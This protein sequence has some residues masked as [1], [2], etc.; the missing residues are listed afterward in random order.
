MLKKIGLTAGTLAIVLLGGFF[1]STPMALAQTANFWTQNALNSLATNTSGGLAT[2]DIHVAHCYIGLGTGTSCGSGGSMTSISNSDGTL[3]LSPDP[4]TTTGTVSINLLN[5]NVWT[6]TAGTFFNQNGI[7]TTPTTSVFVENATASTSVVP[8]QISPALEFISHMR[9]TGGGGSDHIGSF[10]IGEIPVSGASAGVTT[11]GTLQIDSSKDGVY[12]LNILSLGRTGALTASQSITSTNGVIQ[13]AISQVIA[14]TDLI[15]GTNGMSAGHVYLFGGTTGSLS[16]SAPANVTPYNLQLPSIGPSTSGLAIVSDGAGGSTWGATTVTP[17]G[18]DTQIQFNNAGSLGASPDLTY[19]DSG[20]GVLFNVSGL[21]DNYLTLDPYGASALYSFGDIIG[22]M[23]GS[24]FQIN[25]SARTASLNVPLTMNGNFIH[26]VTDPVSAQDV[27]TKNYVD[28]FLT[29]LQWKATVL[30]ATTANI[31]LSGEQT[32]DGVLTSSSRVLVKNQAI[33]SQNGIYVSAAGAWSRS[34]DANTGPE[35]VNAAVAI[36]SGTLGMNTAWVQTTAGPITIGTSPILFVDFLNTT[37]TAGTGLSL[38]G[39]VFSLDTTHANTWTGQQTFDT[40]TAIFNV[41]PTLAT[42]TTNGGILFDNGSG[43]IHQTGAGTSTTVLHGGTFP[44]YGAVNLSSDVTGNLSVTNLNSG[45]SASSSTFWRGDGTWAT[46]AGAV[47]S[48]SNS[49]GTL[50]ISPT[51]GAVVSSLNLGHANSWTATQTFASNIISIGAFGLNFNGLSGTVNILPSTSTTT[52]YVLKLPTAEGAASTVITNDGVGNL[53][54]TNGQLPHVIFTPTTGTT[55]NLTDNKNNI[56]NPS[57]AI[58]ALTLN[59]PAS[60]ANN[61]VI[62]VKFDQGVTTVTY[63]GGTVN[64]A[65][66]S[67][68]LGLFTK[69]TYDSATSTWY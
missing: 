23:N 51:T 5:S 38:T 37:Y 24:F 18:S 36:T 16:I 61:D 4:I 56:I 62:E 35:L 31:T 17:A 19:N 9:Q 57:G 58:L 28:T 14:G 8:V 64:G 59:F 68:G 41:A 33:P 63:T 11:A 60:P 66:A 45:T 55:V 3:V 40:S 65:V 52:S 46:P 50:T 54:F 26:D 20:S 43:V 44:A 2:A 22:S 12:T 21:G 32:I 13:S 27:A 42:L 48:V 39:S 47:S 49:D 6:P 10:R 34:T 67:P 1:R 53:S 25:D 15:S 30:V 69:F 7:A 29:G